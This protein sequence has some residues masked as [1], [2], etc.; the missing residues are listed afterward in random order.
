MPAPPPALS[1]ILVTRD[2]W[3]TLRHALACLQR[4]TA[5]AQL[6]VVVVAPHAAG[7]VAPPGAV[8]G[9]HSWQLAPVDAV[10]NR[11]QAGAA[12][13]RAAR[14]PYIVFVEDHVYAAPDWAA[15]LIAAQAG[16]WAAIGPLVLSANAG[17]L[18]LA[19]HLTDYGHWC[20]PARG[21][22]T[23]LLS[24][25]N[26]CYERAA[27]LAL[28]G[29]LEDWLNDQPRLQR[30]LQAHGRQLL[31]EPRA[32]LWHLNFSQLPAWA[33]LRFCAGWAFGAGRSRGWP[34]VRR[35]LYLAAAPLIPLINLRRLLRVAR[36]TGARGG[37][38]ARLLPALAALTALEALGEL[39]GYFTSARPAV[40]W[41]HEVEFDRP[42]FI[43]PSD[44]RRL[45]ARVAQLTAPSPSHSSSA[46]PARA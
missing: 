44:R 42:R 30:H 1:A 4:Q 10:H 38:L 25:S 3:S 36:R 16:A 7:L 46:P 5:A 14:A 26:T 43:S 21:G 20:D 28:P 23:A 37:A 31:F 17:A 45:E 13:V 34:P 18:P 27:L 24:N 29:A 2:Q 11:E 19:C 9:F 22:P 15:A 41:L 40:A 35:L 12:G 32:R 33:R 6:E 39:A 8:A